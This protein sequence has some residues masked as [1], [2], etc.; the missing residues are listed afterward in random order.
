MKRMTILAAAM[1]IGSSTASAV[2]T[3]GDITGGYTPN[4]NYS[5]VIS[6]TGDLW[7]FNCP[8]NGDFSLFMDTV[9]A[10]MN[11]ADAGT[12]N[13]SGVD[14]AF[15][16]FDGAVNL[17]ATDDDGDACTFAPASGFDCPKLTDFACGIGARH[18][19]SIGNASDLPGG[20]YKLTLTVRDKDDVAISDSAIR[21][22]GGPKPKLPRFLTPTKTNKPLAPLVDDSQMSVP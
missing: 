14:P 13:E 9:G 7:T 17:I 20:I 8:L 22:G 3:T 16:V 4:H 2:E 5:S 6:N 21:L 10:E 12:A 19:I 11:F 1:L 18:Y 15:G